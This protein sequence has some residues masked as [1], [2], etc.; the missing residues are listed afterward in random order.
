[1]SRILMVTPEATPFAK[2]GGLADVLGALPR[3]LAALG[4]EVVV[5]LPR[6]RS[7]T[8][9]DSE[10]IW[11]AMPITM[12]PHNYMVAIDQVVVGAKEDL[13]VRYMFVDCLPLYGRSGIYGERGADYV[14][15]HLRFGVLNLAALAIA[16]HIFRP[17]VFHGHDWP[18]GLLGPYLHETWKADPTFFGA[19]YVLTLH[20]VGYQGNFPASFA[21]DLGLDPRLMH[22]EGLEF[23]GRLSFLKSGIVWADAITT[24]SPTYAREIQTLEYGYGLDGLLRAR[25]DRVTG[26]LNGA[27]YEEW[28]PAVDP[29]LA[30]N[31]SPSD[32]SGKSLVKQALLEEFNL[33]AE[34]SRPVIGIVSR[35]V[36]Q[37][38]FDLL[39]SVITALAATEDFTVIALGSGEP[40]IEE[41]FGQ[42]ARSHPNHFAVQ[43]G[44]DHP[45]S[46]RI[47]AGSDM[48]LMPSLYEPCGLGQL[49]ALRYGTVPIV[50]ATGGLDDTVDETIGFKFQN[51][52]PA[53]LLA[54]IRSALAAWKNREL[55]QA[56]MVRGMRLDFSWDASAVE[57]QKLY[58][59][60]SLTAPTEPRQ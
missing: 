29:H 34:P 35:F 25:A 58:R 39:A 23:W 18:A 53:E 37:K 13:R 17:D 32:L 5:V 4:E 42:L 43:I 12:G 9:Q 48:F 3:A 31:Y 11:H 2:T 40:P 7:A 46:H 56:R 44:Y 36:Y 20:N 52:T 57:Y 33:P 21:A 16:R 41:M 55:W 1:M 15:N 6:Y 10:R 24:V 49:Y 51:H 19:K 59:G 38:G 45:L 22:P 27:D 8:I 26:I 14:D 60:L 50:R 54:A 30:A 47:I 28:N